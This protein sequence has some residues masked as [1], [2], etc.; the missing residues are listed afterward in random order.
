MVQQSWEPKRWGTRFSPLNWSAAERAVIMGCDTQPDS[1]KLMPLSYFLLNTFLH[2]TSVTVSR[3]CGHSGLVPRTLPSCPSCP[4]LNT[5]MLPTNLYSL[6]LKTVRSS[7]RTIQFPG[8]IV[9]GFRIVSNHL[10][11]CQVFKWFAKLD[12]LT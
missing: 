8:I 9:F 1:F 5:T 11:S 2:S 10:I 12:C 7:T 3:I 6:H 4:S